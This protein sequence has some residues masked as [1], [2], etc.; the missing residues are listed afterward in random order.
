MLA[1][2]DHLKDFNSFAESQL[3]ATPSPSMRDL[4]RAWLLLRESH[5]VLADMRA[6]DEDIAAGRVTPVAEAIAEVRAKLGIV[7]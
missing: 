4:F 5:E 3:S 7:K 1:T 2:P 6:S